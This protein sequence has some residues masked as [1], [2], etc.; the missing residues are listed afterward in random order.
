MDSDFSAGLKNPIFEQLEARNLHF[1]NKPFTRTIHSSVITRA[2]PKAAQKIKSGP[3]WL[4]LFLLRQL[5][6]NI[7]THTRLFFFLKTLIMVWSH[8]SKY[9]YSKCLKQVVVN[10]IKIFL[11]LQPLV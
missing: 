5:T 7:L 11:K 8:K 6:L 10:E 1:I 4:I 9:L 2:S 3:F